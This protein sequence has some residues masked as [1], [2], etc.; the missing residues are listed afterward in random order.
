[1]PEDG[2]RSGFPEIVFRKPEPE[3]QVA[4]SDMVEKI[5]P[6]S[7]TLVMDRLS[8]LCTA[9]YGRDNFHNFCTVLVYRVN[10]VNML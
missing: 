7:P 4:L 3:K 9:G 1:V 8:L 2:F 5:P 10:S 6:P